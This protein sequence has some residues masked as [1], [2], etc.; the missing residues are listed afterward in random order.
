ML[1]YHASGVSHAMHAEPG[2]TS[3]RRSGMRAATTFRKLPNARPGRN[4]MAANAT[5]I[6]EGPGCSGGRC[7]RSGRSAASRP[8][9]SGRR[10]RHRQRRAGRPRARRAVDRHV[11]RVLAAWPPV[12]PVKLVDGRPG[13]RD[14]AGRAEGDRVRAELKFDVLA[15]PIVA[16]GSVSGF[17]V[18]LVGPV[19]TYEVPAVTFFS[20]RRPLPSRPYTLYEAAPGVGRPADGD[21]VGQPGCVVTDATS[22]EPRRRPRAPP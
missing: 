7:C 1:S 15:T 13:A 16:L 9:A 22:P 10:E 17:A 11:L 20:R 5:S 19:S 6:S 21:L 8:P 12:Q 14:D 18:S 3:E 4:A 2:L